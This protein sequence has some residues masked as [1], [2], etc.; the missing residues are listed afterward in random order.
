MA[1][2]ESFEDIIKRK[3]YPPVIKNFINLTRAGH[4]RI[5]QTMGILAEQD[6]N[7]K[8]FETYCKAF[9][10]GLQYVYIL[11]NTLPQQILLDDDPTYTARYS[12]S[13]DH[14]TL[15]LQHNRITLSRVG[16]ADLIKTHQYTRISKLGFPQIC[17]RPCDYIRLAGIEEGLHCWQL[18]SSSSSDSY[19]YNA[20]YSTESHASDRNIDPRVYASA[21]VECD[22][23]WRLLEAMDRIAADNLRKTRPKSPPGRLA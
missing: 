5:K 15:A 6:I 23:E 16:L 14:D 3:P 18:S 1:R 2:K 10:D 4:P 22:I 20:M 12:E 13:F 9:A 17:A 21:P 11:H 19:K 8:D 7:P